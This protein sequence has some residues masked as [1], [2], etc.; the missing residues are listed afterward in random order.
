MRTSSVCLI[1]MERVILLLFENYNK[2]KHLSTFSKDKY[3][4]FS[5]P[6]F[7]NHNKGNNLTILS[8][9]KNFVSIK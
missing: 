9:D 8:K 7:E 3:F 5:L 6:F 4:S 1:G 2:G